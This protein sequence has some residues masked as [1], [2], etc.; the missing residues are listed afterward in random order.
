MDIIAVLIIFVIVSVLITFT[1]AGISAAP[2][3][4]LWKS[5]IRRMLK[6]A[7]VQDGEHVYDLGSGD[8]RILLIAAKEFNAK[9]TGF[10]ISVLPFFVSYIKIVIANLKTKYKIKIKFKSMYA[11]DLSEADV[12]T[13]FLTPM[14]TKKLK[15]IF[16]KG[17]KKGCRIVSYAFSIP[18]WEPDEV[19]KP[20]KNKT[21]VYLYKIK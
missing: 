6:V 14:A 3:V 21:S 8:G 7:K 16:S 5:D 15:P 11:Q 1:F 13:M 10:E 4:P 20:A 17:L 9:S 18:G 12:I 19:S 2:W